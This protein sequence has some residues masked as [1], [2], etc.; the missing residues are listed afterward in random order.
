MRALFE[1]LVALTIDSARPVSKLKPRLD[2]ILSI[3]VY[4]EGH[5][6]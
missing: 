1:Q 3:E 2:A 4:A 5:I 6:R